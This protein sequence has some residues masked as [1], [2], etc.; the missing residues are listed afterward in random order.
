MS[1][2]LEI[3]LTISVNAIILKAGYRLSTKRRFS[4][5]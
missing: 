4:G 5:T 2:T 3:E 1:K